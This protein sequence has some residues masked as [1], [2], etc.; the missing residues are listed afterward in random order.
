MSVVLNQ[1][2]PQMAQ[3][4]VGCL[5]LRPPLFLLFGLTHFFSTKKGTRTTEKKK[6]PKMEFLACA[7][8]ELRWKKRFPYLLSVVSGT[9]G[10]EPDR[11][12]E[13][14]IHGEAQKHHGAIGREEGARERHRKVKDKKKRVQ[15]IIH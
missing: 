7:H 4:C 8:I 13:R 9:V 14:R 1:E 5:V 2:Y 11:Q 12:K 6:L 10:K 3:E 15:R